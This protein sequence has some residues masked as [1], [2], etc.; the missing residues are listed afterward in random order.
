VT[1]SDLPLLV[2]QGVI[3]PGTLVWSP[4]MSEWRPVEAIS[5]L[6]AQLF[7]PPP[8]PT[9]GAAGSFDKANGSISPSSI[10]EAKPAS[11]AAERSPVPWRRYLAK[12]L[13]IIAAILPFVGGQV[14]LA[15][16]SPRFAIWL[17][18]P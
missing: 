6:A 18:D 5:E 9:R 14:A 8:L 16:Y 4:D 13:D 12:N 3:G 11:V 1:Q 10:P 15:H 7:V 2:R 17:S